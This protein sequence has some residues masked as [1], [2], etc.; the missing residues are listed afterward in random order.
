MAWELK[1]NRTNEVYPVEAAEGAPVTIGRHERN[2]IRLKGFAV[3]RFHAEIGLMPDGTPY[4]EDM[5]STY[6]TFVNGRKIEGQATV[7]DGDEIRLAV[8]AGFPDG[9]Y[10]LTLK[11]TPDAKEGG[12]DSGSRE[13][14]RPRR[15]IREGR[16]VNKE[17]LPDSI[18][19]VE[20][21]GVFRRHECDE[22]Y[23]TVESAVLQ[24][25]VK[26]VLELSRVEYLNSY[27]LGILVK[28]AQ[29]VDEAGSGVVIA[30]AQGLVLKLFSSIGIDQRL[31]MVSTIE[32][33]RERFV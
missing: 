9:E 14:E 1:N 23:A 26:I 4:I 24:G 32:E 15:G 25:Y 19:L 2:T 6:G 16:I 17:I 7:R 3:N 12:T 11:G 33:A 8:S 22:F 21:E 10:S 5:G 29:L 20:L 31:P 30:G 28:I 27:G 18:L 13:P